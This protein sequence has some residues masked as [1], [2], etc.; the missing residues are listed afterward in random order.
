MVN[1]MNSYDHKTPGHWKGPIVKNLHKLTQP[2]T[3]LVFIDEGIMSSYAYTVRHKVPEWLDMPPVRHANGVTISFA[4][5]HSEHWKWQNQH[6]IKLGNA[7]PSVTV[8]PPVG[9]RTDLVNMQKA[10]WGEI[11]Y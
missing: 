5:G 3:R 1:A 6:T 7:D 11:G 2:G 4:D 9:E 8:T 10:L